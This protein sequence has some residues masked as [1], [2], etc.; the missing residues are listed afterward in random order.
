VKR[1]L[2]ER[3]RARPLTKLI[4]V[5]RTERRHHRRLAVYWGSSPESDARMYAT[6]ISSYDDLLGLDFTSP[7]EPVGHPLLLVCTHGKHDRC[8][9]RYGRPLYTALRDGLDEGWVWQASHVGGD[10]FAGNL[11]VL[12]EG[13]YYGRVGAGDAWPVLEEYLAGRIRLEHY[14]GRCSYPFAVQ[15]AEERV[16]AVAGVTGIDDLRLR[17]ASHEGS[18]WLV[19]FAGAGGG[20]YDVAVTVEPGE[21]THL[22]CNDETLKRPPRFV[23]EILPGSG[24]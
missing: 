12:P 19:R 20:F 11:V 14:R 1:H 3:A 22:T 7:G 10:R 16:R 18:R 17:D 2:R 9:A 5:R 24:A 13:L 6:E 21:L 4:F 15:A 23:A 8:C